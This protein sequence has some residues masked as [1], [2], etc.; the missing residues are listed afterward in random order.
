[1]PNIDELIRENDSQRSEYARYDPAKVD[2]SIVAVKALGLGI[3]IL[4]NTSMLILQGFHIIN[5]STTIIKINGYLVFILIFYLLEFFSTCIFNNSETEDDSFLINDT[6]LHVVHLASILEIVIKGW[7]FP[8]LI[9]QT[10]I[11]GLPLVLIGQFC[12]T[13][14]M[15]TAKE[16][17]NH[18]VQR[19]HVSKHKLVTWGIYKYL[20]HPSYFGFFWWFVGTQL[21]LGNIAVLVVGIIKLWKFF[22]YRIIFEEKF[23]VSFFGPDY[24]NYKSVTRTG[25]PLIQ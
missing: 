4:I 12:R 8:R 22:N 1:M 20:R 23:L 6:D 17:F 7:L 15:C 16:S 14:A 18:Y 5:I 9:V 3:L 13:M 2:L 11:L 21:W 10:S 24:S 19:Q 25:I